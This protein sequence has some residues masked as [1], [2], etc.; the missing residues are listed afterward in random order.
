[1]T[2][3]GEAGKDV[4]GARETAE[5][6]RKIAEQGQR[7]F[8]AFAARAGENAAADPLN[9]WSAFLEAGARM[10]SD[11]AGLARAQADLWSRH[12]ELWRR[13][14]ERLRGRETEPLAAPDAADRRFGHP[15]WSGNPAFDHL[16]QAYL[17]TSRWLVETSRG[18]EGLDHASARKIDFYAR[19]FAD[20]MSPTNFALTNPEVLEETAGSGGANLVRGLSNLLDDLERSADG[21]LRV[22]T[23]GDDAF[24]VGET[25]AASPG[26]VVFQTDLMQ[27]IQFAPRTPRV[28]ARPLV[29]VPPWINKYYVLDLR[30]KNSF[31]RW[32]AERGHTVFVVS[33]VNPDGALRDKAFEDYM[34]EGS[35]A[36][37]GAA[38]EATGA[39]KANLIGYCIGGTLVAATLAWMAAK[40]DGRAASAT[41]FA[42][43]VDFSEPGD[44][45]VFVD[46][47]QVAGL[48]ERM[49]AKGYLEGADMANVFSMLRA[50]DLIW[51]FVI[52]NYLL[53]KAPFPFDLLYWNAD[54]TRMPAAMHSFYLR[55]MYL[56]NALARP[57]GL[58]LA[59]VPIDLGLVR[60]PAYI[61]AAKDDHIAPWRSTYAA[62]RLYGCRPRFVLA[63][64]G[65]IAGVVNPPAAGRYGY[66]TNPRTPKDAE[67]WLAGAT[68]HAGS[69]WPDWDDWVRRR[70]GG[71]TDA[72]EPGAGPLPVLEDAPGSYVMA[73]SGDG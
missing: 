69:W 23:V 47:A 10:M 19:Q 70:A 36:A 9:V 33:W 60:T 2:E 20:A 6:M 72:R 66:R 73:R 4:G 40:D 14:A 35:L 3:T 31:V 21:Q 65:H 34:L 5:A 32:A 42:T 49:A 62:T 59:G 12:A 48:E 7:L 13:A 54:S 22:R 56:E 71:E 11:P 44:L 28:R 58:A 29:I 53:G 38:L 61:L 39:D 17:L 43:L 24:R 64:S 46:E 37:V 15:A 8:A 16:K 67:A 27:L 51:S 52:N 18:I 26:K 45:G 63:S 30:E 57:G 68:E 50:N 55:R 41:F 25:V 1:M